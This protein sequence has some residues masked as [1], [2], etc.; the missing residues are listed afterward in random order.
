M[1][2]FRKAWRAFWGRID[3]LLL[4]PCI[5]LSVMGLV[6]LTG[7]YQSDLTLRLTGRNILSQGIALA[8]GVAAAIILANIN[9]RAL[10]S[11]WQLYVP[12][13]YLLFLSTFIW[14]VAT[15]ARPE[16]KRWLIIPGIEMSIQPSE[17]LKL[18]FILSFAY[19]IYKTQDKFNH[20]LNIFLLCLHAFIPVALVQIQGDSG[21]ALMFLVIF[22]AMMFV[23]GVK[24][25]Y[26]AFALAAI[27]AI[28]PL[29]WNFLLSEKQKDRIL[30]VFGQSA[31][32]Q[33]YYQQMQ[34]AKAVAS[35]GLTGN[36]IFHP[37]PIYV[38]E[39]HNDFI[40]VFIAYSLGFL[41]CAAV[42]L[43]I[44]LIGFKMLVSCGFAT[45]KQG[46][47]ICAGV[48]AMIFGQSAL[49]ICMTLSLL[50][51]IGNSLP[52]LS[53]GGSF[54]LANFLGIGLVMSVYK[55]TKRRQKVESF[56]PKPEQ[57]VI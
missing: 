2:T 26:M 1:S 3:W 7:L 6:L 33:V 40:F 37:S 10:M 21:T 36:G 41:G 51:V 52:F 42:I 5:G 55:H 12:V 46:Q 19:H 22:L 15:P 57:P 31:T 39:L 14:G 16:A 20:P 50:P 11:K 56:L 35:G 9:Y 30:A 53:S 38:P 27:P 18:A 43:A 29:L 49:N 13:S 4:L 17:F 34:A 54:V 45:D 23:A 28:I 44:L 48:F 47:V 32:D 8:A 24:W 25:F